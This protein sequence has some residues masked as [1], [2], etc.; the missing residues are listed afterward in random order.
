MWPESS[1]VKYLNLVKKSVTVT[2]IMNFSKG[3]VFIGAPC[4]FA[5]G[6]KVCCA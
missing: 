1:S 2:E 5:C 6:G 4:V 3:I